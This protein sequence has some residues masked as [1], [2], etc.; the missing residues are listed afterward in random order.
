MIR[1]IKDCRIHI[2]PGQEER[3]YINYQA[4]STRVSESTIRCWPF[5][6]A[7]SK[8]EGGQPTTKTDRT[9]TDGWGDKSEPA[10]P[11]P[12]TTLPK[13]SAYFTRGASTRI[14]LVLIEVLGR[15]PRRFG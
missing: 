3:L 14:S 12:S 10:T 7:P 9:P 8:A 13:H 2:D 4:L 15:Q 1:V 5:I 11:P 6:V